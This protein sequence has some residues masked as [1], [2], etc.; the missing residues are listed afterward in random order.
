M[1]GAE[2]NLPM[3][4]FA[5]PFAD[6]AIASRTETV[7]TVA[8]L[9][10][11]CLLLARAVTRGRADGRARSVLLPAARDG[12]GYLVLA[13]ATR[14][15]V[16]EHRSRMQILALLL[17]VAAVEAARLRPGAEP[18]R[19]ATW[20]VGS[21]AV[22]LGVVMAKWALEPGALSDTLMQLRSEVAE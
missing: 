8:A 12:Y 13:L 3:P 5:R 11:A 21:A 2:L 16:Q 6:A 18:R 4:G 22:C 20:L 9:A 19:G 15:V 10:G 14:F 1:P 7:L 17:L